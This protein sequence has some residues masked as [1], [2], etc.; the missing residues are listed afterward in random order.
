MAL[1]PVVKPDVLVI[2]VV[3]HIAN[4]FKVTTETNAIARQNQAG[5][6][7]RRKGK[8]R[9]MTDRPI[10]VL[11]ATLPSLWSETVVLLP[12]SQRDVHVVVRAHSE[13]LLRD[14][15]ATHKPYVNLFD[16]D[17]LRPN[18]KRV[19]AWLRRAVPSARTLVLATAEGAE[20]TIA[21]LRAGA[22]GLVGTHLGNPAPLAA[23]H[24]VAA[25]EPWTHRGVTAQAI[26]ELIS[27]RLAPRQV[28]IMWLPSGS[29]R[30]WTVLATAFVAPTSRGR[31]ESAGERQK[32]IS[33]APSRKLT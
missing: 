10:W 33:T 29:G 25:G 22:T 30:L 17:A 24:A 2:P 15:V 7:A 6:R 18:R 4:A 1:T 31:S 11:V 16:Y 5:G 9:A 23:L 21:V 12:R 28:P 26:D 19:I 3:V 27:P 13:D 8:G 20:R 32:I 14:A